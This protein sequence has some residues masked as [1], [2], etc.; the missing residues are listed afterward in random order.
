[1]STGWPATAPSGVA[2]PVLNVLV[3]SRDRDLR[4]RFT[5]YLRPHDC[6]AVGMDAMPNPPG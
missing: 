6:G 5:T 4:E 1:M 3:V 2:A